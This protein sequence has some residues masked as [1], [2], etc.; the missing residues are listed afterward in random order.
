MTA[1]KWGCIGDNALQEKPLKQPPSP[2]EPSSLCGSFLVAMGL[3]ASATICPRHQHSLSYLRL[4]VMRLVSFDWNLWKKESKQN[5]LLLRNDFPQAQVTTKNWTTW[6]L[7]GWRMTQDVGHPAWAGSRGTRIHCHFWLSTPWASKL[8]SCE[9]ID[10]H[11]NR[12]SVTGDENILS[13][14]KTERNMI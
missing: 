13:P 6:G 14:R 1:R 8:Y 9:D 5:F 3:V 7:R 10:I 2:E 11:W 12:V 4:T